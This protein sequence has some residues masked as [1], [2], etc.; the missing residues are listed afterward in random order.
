M[1][2]AACLFFSSSAMAKD[3]IATPLPTATPAPTREHRLMRDKLVYTALED[4]I[5]VLCEVE[6]LQ[7]NKL[8]GKSVQ[9]AKREGCQIATLS[10]RVEASSRPILTHE[11]GQRCC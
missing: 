10:S 11:I 1:T 9:F 7:S 5:K 2:G 8:D 3:I 6:D 4:M